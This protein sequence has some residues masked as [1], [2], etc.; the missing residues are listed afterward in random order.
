[1]AEYQQIQGQVGYESPSQVFVR[2][3]TVSEGGGP[4]EQGSASSHPLIKQKVKKQEIPAKGRIIGSMY[5]YI[6]RGMAPS[7]G[8]DP[9][10]PGKKKH[11]PDKPED[12]DDEE[13]EESETDEQTV[14]VTS[15]SQVSAERVK[16]SK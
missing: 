13:D 11:P 10:P 8:D 4:H 6:T 1:M 14:S 3:G 12:E 16:Q 7:G 5:P 2:Q 9:P 15:S